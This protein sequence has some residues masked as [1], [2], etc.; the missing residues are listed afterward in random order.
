[1][2][3]ITLNLD[4]K[5]YSEKPKT[6]AGAISN[7][8]RQ[9][10]AIVSLDPETLLEKIAQGYTFTPAAIGG[11]LEEIQAKDTNGKLLH[12]LADFWQSQQVIVADIDNDTTTGKDANGK[13]IKGAIKHPLTPEAAL[14]ACRGFGIDPYCIY[15][16]FSYSEELQKFRVLLVLEDPITD[17]DTAKDLINRFANIFNLAIAD[18]YRAEG[19]EPETCADTSIEPVKLIFGSRP[20]C[21]IY[22][23]GNYTP[24]SKLMQLPEITPASA[25]GAKAGNNTPKAYKGRTRAPGAQT[26]ALASLDLQTT[27]DINNFDLLDYIERTTASRKTKRHVN[28]CPI[29]SH[30][31]CLEVTGA[32]YRC[33]SENHP[34]NKNG[35]RGGSIIDYLMQKDNLTTAEAYKKFKFEIMQY[36]EAEYQAA[37]R[38]EQNRNRQTAAD[39]EQYYES[40]YK[41]YSSKAGA[42]APGEDAAKDP[43]NRAAFDDPANR[44]GADN[45][46]ELVNLASLEQNAPQEPK[47]PAEDPT[48]T[49]AYNPEN[50]TPPPTPTKAAAPAPEKKLLQLMSAAQYLSRNNEDASQ[51]DTDIKELKKYGRRK[52]GLH[53]SIDRYLTLFPG[54]AALGGQASL[55]KT[56]FAVNMVSK[57]L[58]RGEYV[59][60]F[61]LEQRAEELITK[62]VSQ[63]IY[64]KNPETRTN[65]LDLGRG[66]RGPEISEALAELPDQLEHYHIIECDFE[67]TAADIESLVNA[68]M[69][70]NP[71]IKPIVIIDYLQLIAPPEDLRGGDKERID[72]NLKA[73]KRMQKEN[74]LFVLVISSFNRSS[75]ME[76]ISYESFFGTSMIEFTC[77][78]VF[79]LQLQIQDAGNDDFYKRSQKVETSSFEKKQKIHAAQ[80]ESPKKVQFVSIKNRRGKQYFTANFNYYPAHDY[81]E[82]DYFGNTSGRAHPYNDIIFDAIRK[83]NKGGQQINL[84][85]AIE[86][87]TANEE[88]EI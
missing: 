18:Q 75:N 14:E 11:S 47:Q 39:Y 86:E 67:T 34:T 25:S 3:H 12:N 54:L 36:D 77:D 61:A 20:D 57:L 30:N 9:A 37:W 48:P 4:S 64:G 13:A 29:C 7:R 74:N 15:K 38:A 8:T 28:P 19:A 78:Y 79:G 40:I 49:E 68:F 56:T 44:A 66:E 62:T 58:E 6:K 23:S 41:D 17:I 35:S 27:E 26:G 71:A 73:L 32:L 31:D 1:M 82:P 69:R 42:I 80:Q 70:E 88:Y 51:Y 43:A 46:A 52:M 21:I 81:F 84:K 33:Y 60:Y 53:E 59:L 50:M 83:Q 16:T 2:K 63:Y 22:K 45:A 87:T 76:P 55:G 65:N 85:Q 72:Y 24:I 5:G 10:G